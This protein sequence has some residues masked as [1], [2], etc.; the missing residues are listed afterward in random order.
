MSE[1]ERYLQFAQDIVHEAATLT[2]GWY[3]RSL[4]V[5]AKADDSPVTIAD[6]DA[7]ALIWR[8]IER[9]FP[10]HGI[11]GEEHGVLER[12]QGCSWRWV[13]DPI[14]GT[15]SFIHGV[16][17]YTTLLGLLREDESVVGVI[18][19]PALGQQVAAARGMGT[20][21]NGRLVRTSQVDRLRDAVGLT[22]DMAHLARKHNPAL[23]QPVFDRC[24]FVRTWGDAY[25]HFLVATGRAEFI[26]DAELAVHDCACLPVIL[27]EAGGAFFD[28][29]GEV[30][31]F[32]GH[33]IS[34]N[35]ALAAV[36]RRAVVDGV[37]PGDVA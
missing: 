35:G 16:P 11:I 32:G 17:L 22:T 28:W 6:R 37:L 2:L 20:R 8:A 24:R 21:L 13:I 23:W 27:E 15:K 5:I 4:E 9:S 26:L 3:Q 1:L 31:V 34:C 14:D 25:G 30:T 29:R 10:G 36:I 33:G 7:E 12:A 19:V 18:G